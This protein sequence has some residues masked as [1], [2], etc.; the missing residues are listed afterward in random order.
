MTSLI[1]IYMN[2]I[3]S[4]SSPDYMLAYGD[5]KKSEGKVNCSHT[6]PLFAQMGAAYIVN[7]NEVW[8]LG[9]LKA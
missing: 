4:F 7:L 3:S 8:D 2:P 6:R 9:L 1:S 5:C